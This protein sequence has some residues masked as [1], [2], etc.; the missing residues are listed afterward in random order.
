MRK[1]KESVS[2]DSGFASVYLSCELDPTKAEMAIKMRYEEPPSSIQGA[3]RAA[4][5]KAKRLTKL[6]KDN[7]WRLR[8]QANDTDI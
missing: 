6:T 3:R 2:G 1:L 8:P 5:S 7:I 4:T